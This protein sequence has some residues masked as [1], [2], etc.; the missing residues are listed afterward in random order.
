MKIIIENTEVE[1][2][3]RDVRIAKQIIGDFM[4]RVKKKSEE[5][6][7]PLFYPTFLILMHMMSQDQINALTPQTIQLFLK[8]AYGSQKKKEKE[9]KQEQQD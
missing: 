2:S 4:L 8:A 7:A 3:P 1:L 9:K 6:N 5:A